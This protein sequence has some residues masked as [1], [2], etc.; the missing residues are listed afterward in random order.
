MKRL[1]CYELNEVP[2]RVVD[3][4]VEMRPRSHLARLLEDAAQIT[5]HTVDS[6]ELHPWSTWPTMHRGV[7]NDTHNIRYINQDLTAA[8]ETPALWEILAS[9]GVTV[10]IVGCLQSY[11]PSNSAN[12]LFH[13]PDTF[14][15]GPETRPARYAAFQA[16]NLKLTG[17]NK[18]VTSKPGARDLLA[19]VGLLRC[20][21]SPRTAWHLARHLARERINPLHK[22]LRATMQAHVA[23][24]VFMDALSKSRPGYA[25]FFTNHVAGVM[26]RYWKYTFPEDFEYRLQDGPDLFHAQSI[27]KAMDIFDGQLGQL[28]HFADR[29]GYDLV[30]ASSMGQQAVDR[31]QYVPEL[32][33]DSVSAL[34][35]RLGFD[36]PV[37]MNLAMQ[38]DV[39]LEFASAS[40]LAEFAELIPHLVSTEGK[41]ILKIRYAPQGRTLNV[42]VGRSL[43][44]ARE[45]ALVYKG[46]R[47]SLADLGMRTISRDPGTG[48]HQPDGILV[49]KGRGQP[50]VARRQVIDSRQYAPTVLAALGVT[51]PSYMMPPVLP[52][53]ADADMRPEV[54]LPQ[55]VTA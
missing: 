33:L 3:R 50:H 34:A 28:A 44:I 27:R 8:R 23:F 52:R 55:T 20:G 42:S 2:W 6:G 10:G 26:H 48:Y 37:K 35:A 39:A 16:L 49:W 13:V 14:A 29:N 30:I 43:A 21:V 31:G 32:M 11:P 9:Q 51:P 38:P 54:H 40:D 22:T 25:A 19:G 4:Y 17:E 1:L 24:D 45:Q 46:T 7:S 36:R 18:A 12:I 41:Q 47:Y 15:A 53:P 5:T